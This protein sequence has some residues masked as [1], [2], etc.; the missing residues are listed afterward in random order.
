[1]SEQDSTTDPIETA[2]EKVGEAKEKVQEVV[3]ELKSK[4]REVSTDQDARDA[5]QLI[6][7]V[8]VVGILWT[9]RR[10]YKFSKHVVKNM[11]K[12]MVFAQNVIKELR[13]TGTKFTFYPGVGIY[14]D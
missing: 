12:Q 8:A 11:D 14:V 6:T 10:Q 7:C 3:T 4:R 5:L 13:S 2:K 1:M 9:T